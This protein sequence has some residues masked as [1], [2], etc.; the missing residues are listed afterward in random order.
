M[1]AFG[2]TNDPVV[3]KTNFFIGARPMTREANYHPKKVFDFQ[4]TI[5]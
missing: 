1:L 5:T 3:N 4:T 2:K